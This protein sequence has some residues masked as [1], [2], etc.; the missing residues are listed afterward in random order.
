MTKNKT[1]DMVY[2]AMGAVVIAICSWISIPMPVPFTMQTFAVFSVV[3]LLGGKR[4]TASIIVYILLGA[5]G[6]PVFSGFTSGIGVLLGTTGGYIVG[7]AGTA[8][9]MW[10]MEKISGNRSVIL[11][12][13]MLLGLLV[14]YLFGTVWFMEVYGKTMG[15]VG[16]ATVLG[17]CVLPFVIPDLIKIALAVVL[18]RR[19]SRYVL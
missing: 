7:F 12:G 10:G 11:A 17:W 19:L 4:G 3:G 8:L 2:I 16:L 9:L 18:T 1:L 5:I 15:S 13:S 6:L 14:C